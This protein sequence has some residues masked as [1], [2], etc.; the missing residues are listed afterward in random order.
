MTFGLDNIAA[1]SFTE[2]V[3]KGIGLD[4]VWTISPTKVLNL[5]YSLTRYEEPGYDA[6]AGFNETSLGIPS[7]FVGQL[8]RA[9]FPYIT[10]V[11]GNFGTT[12]TQS[13]HATT[14]HTLGRHLHAGAR[15]P[16]LPLW[17]RVLGAARLQF[18]QRQR[19][20]IR[21]QQ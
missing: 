10:G 17:R 2:R 11:A 13:F 21:F 18:R 20:R 15:Q 16:Y 7:S 4:H 12:Q 3:N 6:G 8:P 9:G 1:G 5:H 14:Y 19:R